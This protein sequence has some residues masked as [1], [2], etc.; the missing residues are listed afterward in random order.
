MSDELICRVLPWVGLGTKEYIKAGHA[1]LVL[2]NK[3]TGEA[4]YYDFGRYIT[5]SGFGRVRSFKTDA[6]LKI[7]FKAH[8]DID[9]SISNVE[10]FL[11][12][13]DAH[14]EKTHGDGRL[15]AS[16]CSS[17]NFEIAEQTILDLQNKGSIPYGAFG[18]N[19]SNCSRF[20]T[21]VLVSSTT[22]KSISKRLKWN[23][24]FTPSAIGNVEI[25]SDHN[26]F[27]VQNGIVKI[28]KGSA[29]L[30]NLRNYFHKKKTESNNSIKQSF[31]PA[32]SQKLSG[33]GSNAWFELIDE[34]LSNNRFRIRRYNDHHQLD[35][36]G[37]YEAVSEFDPLKEYKFTYDSH[38]LY[39][40]I[41]QGD[42]KIRFN[43]IEPYEE[44]SL[45]QKVHSA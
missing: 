13:L 9:G 28:F 37:I 26:L 25:S 11:I 10:D 41:K 5:P 17:I 19:T 34:N 38:C 14:P 20:V 6:E 24:L 4:N 22:N 36:D 15:I 23:Q 21:D 40:H 12:W 31:L 29:F 16:M 30:E 32:N 18:K 2:I 8:F 45:E 35:F 7:P 33:I 39:C 27:E 3:G 44:I 43:Y 1:A 42:A